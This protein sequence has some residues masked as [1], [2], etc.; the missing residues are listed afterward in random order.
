MEVS[1]DAIVRTKKN[2]R[3][4]KDGKISEALIEG[5]IDTNLFE[6]ASYDQYNNL[7]ETLQEIVG[8]KVSKKEGEEITDTTSETD[9]ET[10][11]R[12]YSVPITIYGVC[13]YLANKSVFTVH[14]EVIDLSKLIAKERAI[15]IKIGIKPRLNIEAFDKYDNQ[16]YTKDYV[17]KFDATFIDSNNEEHA[18]TGAYDTLIEKVVYTSNTPVTIVGDVKVFLIYDNKTIINISNVIIIIGPGDSIQLN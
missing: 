18:S 3:Y 13:L 4:Y 6:V 14:P 10:G 8:I 9:Q 17:N 1:P 15:P 2:E 11:Y 12:K 5:N 7:A 16:L